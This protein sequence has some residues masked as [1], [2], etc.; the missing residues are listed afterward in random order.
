MRQYKKLGE[1]LIE[2]GLIS[3]AQLEQALAIQRTTGERLGKILIDKKWITEEALLDALSERFGIPKVQ[4]DAYTIDP[5]VV[6]LV[7]MAMA[8]QYKLIPLFRVQNTLTIAM[9]D[10][11]DIYAIDAVRYQ[12]GYQ[13]QE[14]IASEKDIEAAIK[15]YYSMVD[16]MDRMISDLELTQIVELETEE[17]E[18]DFHSEDASD[19]ASIIKLVNMILLQAIRD[20]ASDVHLEPDDNVFRIRYRIDGM[21]HEISKPSLALAP[22][23]ISRIKIMADLDVSERRVPQDGRLRLR[24]DGREIDVRVSILPTVYGEKAVL[25]VLDSKNAIIELEKLGFH[26]QT[27]K[28]W[29]NVIKSPEGIILI[30]GPTGSGKTTTLYAVLNTINSIEKNIVTVENPVE[31]KFPLINQVQINPK[32]G[33]TFASALRSILRQDPDIIMVGEIRDVETAEIAIRSALTGHLVLSTLHT[34]DAPG[35]VHRLIDMGIE[36]F[37]VS[38]SLIAVMAQRL[39]RR[40]C[41]NCK[42]VDEK[43]MAMLEKAGEQLPAGVTL[44]KGRGCRECKGTGYSGRTGIHEL[45]IMDETLRR[46]VVDKLP[47]D[48]IRKYAQNHGMRT[49][50]EDGMEKVFAGIT[51]LEEVIRVSTHHH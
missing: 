29:E 5:A 7:P 35:A 27:L 25:R 18:A 3:Q 24:V 37:L 40:I 47:T 14:A 50:R 43:G 33:L 4:I 1:I 11:L 16:S 42:V 2:K 36:P 31:Y 15:K 20:R 13:V 49:L 28:R 21:L 34:N 45:L 39:V 48:E 44:Y 41:A 23:I 32:V 26:P 12:T 8:Q 30:T 19:E 6:K 10:P 17:E 22:M 46:M 38:S 51:T 9:A